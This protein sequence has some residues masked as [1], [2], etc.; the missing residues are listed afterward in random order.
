[1]E[2]CLPRVGSNED[3]NVRV[4]V[5]PQREE[6]LIRPRAPWSC[7][8][9]SQNHVPTADEQA[10]RGR[11]SGHNHGDPPVFGTGWPHE[12]ADSEASTPGRA[13]RRRKACWALPVISKLRHTHRS[14]GQ[15]DPSD[16]ILVFAPS[17]HRL[18]ASEVPGAASELLR[19]Q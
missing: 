18:P 11:N 6:V 1:M 10:R 17:C 15:V 19:Q 5:F 7:L 9:R 16:L 3:G 2:L 4:G 14:V 8:Q 12:W 13:N